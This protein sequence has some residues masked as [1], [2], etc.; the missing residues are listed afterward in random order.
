MLLLKL[1]PL[2]SLHANFIHLLRDGIMDEIWNFHEA[3]WFNE[4]KWIMLACVSRSLRKFFN[5][6]FLS[7]Y[8]CDWCNVNIVTAMI[9]KTF[10]K[11]HFTSNC[12]KFLFSYLVRHANRRMQI[13]LVWVSNTLNGMELV[14]LKEF[15]NTILLSLSMV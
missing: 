13:D 1:H 8:V 5:W 6:K 2:Q 10:P 14:G 11:D 4:G 3:H 15:G 9:I 7:I 12:P